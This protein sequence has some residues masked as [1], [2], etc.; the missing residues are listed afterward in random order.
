ME[1]NIL[2]VSSLNLNQARAQVEESYQKIRSPRIRQL[3]REL[4]YPYFCSVQRNLIQ[5]IS[6][7]GICLISRSDLEHASLFGDRLDI[8]CVGVLVIGRHIT[9]ELASET[10]ASIAVFGALIAPQHIFDC[11]ED[12]IRAGI[13]LVR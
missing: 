7:V 3:F 6:N 13:R 8:R 2:D 11:I 12:R 5:K 10:I 9:A 1:A 4:V